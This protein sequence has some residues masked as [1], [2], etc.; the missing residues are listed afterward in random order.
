MILRLAWRNL[1]R[2]KRRTALTAGAILFG[3]AL[4]GMQRGLQEGTYAENIRSFVRLASGYIQIQREGYQEKPGLR[5]SFVL[6]GQL[7]A[8]LASTPGLRGYAPRLRGD[9][10]VSK[11]QRTHI[12]FLMGVDPGRELV[13]SDFPKRVVEGD[14]VS[15][16]DEAGVV[17]GQTLFKNLDAAIGDSLVLIAQGFD[18]VQRDMFVRIKGVLKTASHDFDRTILFMHIQTAQRLLAMEDRVSLVA[19]ALDDLPR[20]PEARTHLR[21]ELMPGLLA[22][23]WDE[24]M[25]EMKA[26]IEADNVQGWFYLGILFTVVAFGILNTML[27]SVTERSREF[28]VMLALGVANGTLV[29]IVFSELIFLTALGLFLGN[30]VAYGANS[31]IVANPIEL[32]GADMARM[33]EEY[34]FLPILTSSVSVQVFLGSTLLIGGISLVAGIIPLFRVWRL[35]PLKGIRYT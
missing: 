15:D 28:G 17:V 24:V 26:N 30:L 6:D 22:L 19:V 35:Q 12:A 9:G 23:A 11:K 10:L 25:P 13:V 4:A 32:G 2:N 27:M 31:V 33:Y 5:K 29:W 1:G 14:F 21:T 7:R 34:G 8:R 3:L 20:I 16:D 18:G